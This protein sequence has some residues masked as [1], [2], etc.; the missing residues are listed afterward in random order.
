MPSSS[1]S[2]GMKHRPLFG[3]TTLAPLLS[4]IMSSQDTSTAYPALAA[5]WDIQSLQVHRNPLCPCKSTAHPTVA[6]PPHYS[7]PPKTHSTPSPCRCAG[8][9][10]HLAGQGFPYNSPGK[11]RFARQPPVARGSRQPRYEQAVKAQ[12]RCQPSVIPAHRPT[13]REW[14]PVTAQRRRTRDRFPITTSNPVATET[15]HHLRQHQHQQRQ[16]LPFSLPRSKGPRR[17]TQRGWGGDYFSLPPRSTPG[18]AR[19][20]A[21]GRA[22]HSRAPTPSRC[23]SHPPSLLP[24]SCAACR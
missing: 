15:D 7:Q 23:N 16:E 4:H 9:P 22:S 21:P 6:G 1:L 24:A 20:P 11:P 10:A 3:R 18:D 5:A 12:R 8:H 14:L 19:L 17:P 2:A 13:S